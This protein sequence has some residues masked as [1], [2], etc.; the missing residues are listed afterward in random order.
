[1]KTYLL[2][3]T[4]N[5]RRRCGATV[6]LFWLRPHTSRLQLTYLFNAN[7]NHNICEAG[8]ASR[9]DRKRSDVGETLARRLTTDHCVT[10][11]YLVLSLFNIA[12]SS[13]KLK[14]TIKSS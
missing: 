3:V 12:V 13:I 14:L 1:M 10:D 9:N 7:I 4:N 11:T 5:I 8:T 2:A 6:N